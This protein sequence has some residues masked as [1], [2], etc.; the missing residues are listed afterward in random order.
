MNFI[1]RAGRKLASLIGAAWAAFDIRD[2]LV[3]GGLAALGYGL[4][5]R[6]GLW[7]ALIICGALLMLLGLGFLIRP[8]GTGR[9]TP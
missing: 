7:L 9:R 6:W 4:H 1:R 5:L 2:I 8:I 3:F